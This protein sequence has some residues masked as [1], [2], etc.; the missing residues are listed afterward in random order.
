MILYQ[1]TCEVPFKCPSMGIAM[2]IAFVFFIIGAWVYK[3]IIE[4]NKSEVGK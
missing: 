2:A 1:T 4:I 3:R